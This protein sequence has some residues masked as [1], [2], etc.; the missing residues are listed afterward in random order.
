MQELLNGVANQVPYVIML[1]YFLNMYLKRLDRY[2]EK[3]DELHD[4]LLKVEILLKTEI[5][6]MHRRID[7]DEDDD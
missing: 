7:D 3:T 1:G 4:R 5:K 6:N 2:I